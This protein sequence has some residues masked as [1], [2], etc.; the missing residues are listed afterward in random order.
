MQR[1]RLAHLGI[2]PVPA[3]ILLA[4]E[5]HGRFLPACLDRFPEAEVTV[6]DASSGMLEQARA[7]LA[8]AG[9]DASRVRFIQADILRWQRPEADY[10]LIVTH[11]FLDCFTAAQIE[12]VV[13]R[14]A[15][16]AKPSANWLLADFRTDAPGLKGL[17]SRWIVGLLYNFFRFFT[18]IPAKSLASPDLALDQSGF[19]LHHEIISEWGLLKSQWWRR[20]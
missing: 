20:S 6:L 2:I 19:I 16:A 5:G 9:A 10:D 13:S 3:K 8:R 14:L 12:I 11:F 7:N 4:G 18:R 17:R 1:C 15:T